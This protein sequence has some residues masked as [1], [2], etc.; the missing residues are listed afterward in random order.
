MSNADIPQGA[1][2][3]GAPQGSGQVPGAADAAP[4]Q[5]GP[6]PGVDYARQVTSQGLPPD[7]QPPGGVPPEAMPTPGGQVPPQTDIPAA[8]QAQYF[9][10][11]SDKKHGVDKCPRCGATEITLRPSTGMLVCQ[12]CRHEW[13]EAA[14]EDKFGLTAP[15]G[16]LSGRLLGSGVRDIPEDVSDVVTIK[17]QACGA[18]VV[19]NTAESVH[20]RCH[21]CRNTLSINAQIPNGAV[22]DGLLPFALPKEEAIKRIT[23]FVKKRRFYA[24]PAFTR[25][26]APTEVVGVYLPYLVI[27]ANAKI[28]LHGQAEVETRRYTRQ[29]SKDRSE[30]FYDADVYSVKRRFRLLADDVVIESSAERANM[31][32]SESTNNVINSIQPFDLKNAV[33]YNAH[34]L[35]GFTSERRNIQ[36]EQIVPFAWSNVLSVGRARVNETLQAYDRGVR[37]EHE[38]IEVEGS[39]WVSVY[40]P[41]WLYS[42]Y[43]DF[44]NGKGLKHYVA[45]NGRTGE[46]MGS[47]P[48][49]QTRLITVTTI[50]GIVGTILGGLVAFM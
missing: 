9:D 8:P 33:A 34:Y 46:T 24:L 11:S 15:I 35:Q 37:W 7:Y 3:P 42:Y 17:C 39:R 41:V 36:V 18:E 25:S 21:W 4:G 29:V 16:E 49:N 6:V 47:I 50:I 5:A 48:I 40:L 23:E 30:T 28:E 27:D 32:T 22:P 19:I 10:T 43:Q 26:F 13:A 12:F 38:K 31:D 2:Y 44:G 20:S 1:G 45:V 14:I